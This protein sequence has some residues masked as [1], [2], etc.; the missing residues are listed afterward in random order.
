MN[1]IL[2]LVLYGIGV[3]RSKLLNPS[4]FENKLSQCNNLANVRKLIQ[5]NKYNTEQSC[6]DT[7]TLMNNIFEHL[8]LKYIRMSSPIT[9]GYVNSFFQ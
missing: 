6:S 1:R 8:S 7:I 9:E 5:E 2:N 3:I 4:E